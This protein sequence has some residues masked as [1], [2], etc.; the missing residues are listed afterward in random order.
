M[1]LRLDDYYYT[2]TC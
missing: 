2:A 1:L